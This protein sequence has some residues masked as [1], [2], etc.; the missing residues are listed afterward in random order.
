[1]EFKSS[2]VMAYIIYYCKRKPNP[3]EVTATKAQR[4]LYCCY[5]VVL[6]KSNERL[7]DEHPRAWFYAPVFP[8]VHEAIKRD[9]LTVGMAKEFERECPADT[10]S[11]VNETIDTFGKYTP[12]QLRKWSSMKGSP[13]DKADPLCA[14]DDREIALFFKPYIKVIK[15][16]EEN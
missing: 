8:K 11:L 5:G 15:P 9:E 14:L 16:S 6:G 1:M 2:V 10:L 12:I 4:L 13:Y 3:I 7:T